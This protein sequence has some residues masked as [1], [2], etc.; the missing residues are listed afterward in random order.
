MASIMMAL[1][2]SCLFECF[3]VQLKGKKQPLDHCGEGG[4]RGAVVHTN[5]EVIHATIQLDR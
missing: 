1:L 2:M 3:L 4:N 5:R